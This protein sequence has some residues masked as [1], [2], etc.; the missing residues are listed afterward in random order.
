MSWAG[1]RKVRHVYVGMDQKE[2]E[3]IEV[4]HRSIK[5][6]HPDPVRVIPIML[7]PLMRKGLYRRTWTTNDQGQRID[8][9]DGL[10][11]ST[12]FAFTRFLTP[13]LHRNQLP[14]NGDP[15]ALFCDSDFMFRTNIEQLFRLADPHY[16]IMCVK[17]VHQPTEATKMSGQA[18]SPYPRKNWSSLML[19]NTHHPA[20]ALLTIHDVNNQTGRW[21]HGLGWLE[22]DE[23]GALP[24]AWNWLEG[25]SDP[26]IEPKAVHFTRGVPTHQGMENVPYA[27]EWRRLRDHG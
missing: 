4:C 19:W 5:K 23:I 14:K 7:E 15:W 20:N 26:G 18:Q 27:D 21:L 6:H 22:D 11:F 10:P 3:A 13:E 1:R 16:A 24:E 8:D 12:D 17:H 9:L 25:S 2:R